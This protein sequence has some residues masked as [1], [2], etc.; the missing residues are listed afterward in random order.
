MDLGS[1]SPENTQGSWWD[2]SS[3]SFTLSSTKKESAVVVHLNQ[4]SFRVEFKGVIFD[5]K[6]EFDETEPATPGTTPDWVVSALCHYPDI[7]E[8]DPMDVDWN[9]WNEEEL[10]T[11]TSVYVPVTDKKACEEGHVLH[12]SLY[13][14]GQI[15]LLLLRPPACRTID[16]KNSWTGIDALH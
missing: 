11:M 1:C 6:E 8:D 7:F 2:R 16:L 13:D 9:A 14:K 15:I 5:S 3:S 10:A 4:G 12:L